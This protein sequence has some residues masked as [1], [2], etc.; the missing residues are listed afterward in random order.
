MIIFSQ[1]Q[2]KISLI[3][4]CTHTLS[5][6]ISFHF[7]LLTSISV[8]FRIGIHIP[9]NSRH[10]HITSSRGTIGTNTFV[11]QFLFK[12]VTCRR[13]IFLVSLPIYFCLH[14]RANTYKCISCPHMMVGV[15][16][17]SYYY[18]LD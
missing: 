9:H 14:T 15:V 2:S 11:H 13:R 18:I 7:L 10:F 16:T 3:E 6:S 1:K 5:P 8:H 17:F 12:R 4:T